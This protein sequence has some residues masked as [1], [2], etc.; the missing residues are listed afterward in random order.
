MTNLSTA[1]S[2]DHIVSPNTHIPLSK[3]CRTATAVPLPKI[4]ATKVINAYPVTHC[5]LIPND[6]K[7]SHPQYDYVVVYLNVLMKN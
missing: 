3:Q 2:L 7:K 4:Y 5:R 6:G 1:L